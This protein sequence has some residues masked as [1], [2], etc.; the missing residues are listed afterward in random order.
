MRRFLWLLL[1]P[2]MTVSPV[3][4]DEKMLDGVAAIVNSNVITYS[5]VREFVRPVIQQLQRE[6]SGEEL[7]QK[8]RVAEEDALNNLID[9]ALIIHEFNTKG[10]SI[11][12]NVIEQ[13]INEVIAGEY[14]GDRTAF[15]K[16]LQARKITYAQYR[17]QIRDRTIIQAMRHRKT[18]QEIVVS[19]YRIEQHYKDHLADYKVDDQI[20]LRMIFIK[21]NAPTTDATTTDPRRQLGDS[22]VAKLDGGAKF[23]DLAKQYSDG[24]EAKQGGEWGW[25][26][27]DAL[28]KELN[29]VAFTLKP[30]QHSKLIETKEGYYILHVD[31]FRAAHTQ[32]LPEV[33]D[34]IEKH[35]LE[36]QRGKMMENWVRE[37]RAHAFIRMF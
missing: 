7:V 33:R 19:P 27:K 8:I 31:D 26:G 5:E 21:K 25:V 12:E 15:I 20:K 2:A 16:T 28:R 18:E 3:F 35:L 22:L 14:G 9:R 13:Q 24:K 36:E 1:L 17:D 4:A 23:E 30:G 6:T 11:P 29:E 34:A 10:F 32:T 37:L